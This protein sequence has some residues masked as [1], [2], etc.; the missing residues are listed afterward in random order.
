MTV[1]PITR[2]ERRAAF[3]ALLPDDAAL[4]AGLGSVF[5]AADGSLSIL[6]REPNRYASSFPS[7]IVTCRLDSGRELLLLCKYEAGQSHSSHGHRGNVAYEADVYREIVEPLGTSAPR[8]FGSHAPA[9]TGDTWLVIEYVEDAVAVSR[10]PSRSDSPQLSA[11]WIGRFH[12]ASAARLALPPAAFLK[13]Y[14]AAYYRRWAERT[15]AL[16]SG[17]HASVPWL[18]PLCERFA[19]A[20]DALVTTP[21]VIHGEYTP[22]NTLVQGDRVC[23]VDWESAAVAAGEVD[24]AAL[25]DGH[26]EPEVVDACVREYE[27]ARWPAG[28]PR[29]FATTL[30]LARLYWNF[31][32]LGERLDWTTG[33]KGVKRLGY[34]RTAAERMGM[35]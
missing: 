34:L 18:A 14:D 32:W 5:G 16:A 22:K 21:T 29:D 2:D 30:G 9:S 6:R 17:L 27:L 31:R 8:F 3:R 23:P 26:W 4:T 35:C 24:L 12:A 11:R 20:V 33:E 13:R 15:K 19:G 25:T 28:A 1:A 7:E 10:A